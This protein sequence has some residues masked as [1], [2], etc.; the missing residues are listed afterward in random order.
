MNG[1]LSRR[2]FLA[3][4]TAAPALNVLDLF[5]QQAAK[6][7]FLKEIDA[8]YY[9]HLDHKQTQ[10]LVCPLNCILQPG[11]TC[12]CRTRR[13]HDGTL[14]SHAYNNP[15]TLS[16]DPIEKL[17]LAHFLPGESTLSLAVGGCNLRCLYCQNWQQSQVKPEELKTFD[18]P[19][20]KAVEGAAK[21]EVR[22]LAYTYTEP[23]AFY[24]YARDVSVL[25]KEKGLKNVVATALFINPDP[26]RELCKTTDAFAVALKGFDEKFYE[27]VLGSD[28]KPVL[29]GLEVIR[30]EKTWLEIVTLVVPG[31]NDDLAKI[32]EMTGWIAKNLG[33]KVPLHFGRFV[34][35]YRLKDL[36]R[37]PVETL[38]KCRQIALD[39]G[40]EHVLIFNVSPHEGNNT[41][42]ARCKKEVIQRLGFKT[43]E[44]HHTKGV[45]DY[46]KTRLPG[47]WEWK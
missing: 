24:E 4:L 35:E 34:P 40:L 30:E 44:S 19:R 2:T 33:T 22:I 23:V 12:F 28:L 15:C 29:R 36:P 13:N 16:I 1:S 47:V 14:L 38:E 6:S 20:E 37:T 39:A 7:N 11:Q 18:L 8:R 42:C 41:R 43:I 9:K 5:A 27:K 3:G 32:K 17:P 25:A 45:C 26:L 31:Y 21:K 10:C 46:C